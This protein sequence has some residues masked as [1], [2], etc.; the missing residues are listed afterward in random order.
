MKVLINTFKIL[1]IFLNHER[2][3]ALDELARLS[4]MNKTTVNRI[5]STLVD[6]GY[7]IQ[8]EK[9]GKYSLGFKYFDF[10]TYIKSHMKNREL[11]TPFL[12]KLARQ[13]NESASIALWD[14]EKTLMSETFHTSTEVLQVVP[15]EGSGLP[16]HST[17]LGKAVLANI[18]D[19]EL[20]KLFEGKSLERFTPNTIT[21]FEDLKKH[22]IIVRRE[23]I[24]FD[25]EETH[26]GVRGIAA[27][28]RGLEGRL[29]GS[30]GIVGPSVRI[31]RDKVR[32][33]IRP[34]KQCA[35]E[36][37][38][39]LGYLEKEPAGEPLEIAAGDSRRAPDKAAVT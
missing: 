18:T 37:S 2:E 36:I 27:E 31:T 15:K 35:V 28:I 13:F 24:A 10:T 32:E 14:G 20:E 7:L 22:L 33:L 23:G 19:D 12:V 9:R 30:V 21:D 5:V 39:T 34:I 29:V 8:R 38:R 16:L 6:H 4:G 11:V 25:D 1:D 17:S 26:A 3:I